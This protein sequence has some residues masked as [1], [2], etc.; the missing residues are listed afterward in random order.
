[1]TLKDFRASVIARATEMAPTADFKVPDSLVDHLIFIAVNRAVEEDRAIRAA[2]FIEPDMI[3]DFP[4]LP[5]TED[6]GSLMADF[7]VPLPFTPFQID[8]DEGIV[9]VEIQLKDKR[10]RDVMYVPPIYASN[11][12][13]M[14][15]DEPHYTRIKNDLFVFKCGSKDC[16][17]NVRALVG[18]VRDYESYCG[19]ED[20]NIPIPHKLIARAEEIAAGIVLQ[21][22]YGVNAE[23]TESGEKDGAIQVS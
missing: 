14:P 17:V 9:S 23:N 4:D 13:R 22:L 7:M 6:S 18:A 2:F 21:S 15:Y 5:K 8:N 10:F 16:K 12:R 20:I 1:M 19:A 3:T 11:R